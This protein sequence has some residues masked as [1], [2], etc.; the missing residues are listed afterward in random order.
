MVSFNTIGKLLFIGI[1]LI[2]ICHANALFC[3]TNFQDVTITE[4]VQVKHNHNEL[5]PSFGTG[6]AWFDCDNDGDLDLI[7]TNRGRNQLFR[8]NR[9]GLGTP[10]FTDITSDIVADENRD[11]CGVAAADYDNDGDMDLYLANYEED[12]LLQNDGNGNFTDVTE[13]AFPGISPFIPQFGSTAA[14]GDLNNDGWLDIYISN[15]SHVDS[16]INSSD[17]LFIS[18]G[19]SPLTFTDRS[20]LISG[21]VDG[22]GIDDLEGFGLS[23]IIT[24]YNNDGLMDIFATND[25]PLGPEG[26]KLWRNDGN[27]NFTEVISEVGPFTRGIT[28]PECSDVM[29]ITRGDPNH[30]G[31]L[32]YHLTNVHIYGENT[33]LLQNNGEN[34]LNV[35][36]PSGMDKVNFAPE[37]GLL[38]TWGTV[39]IDYDLDTWQDIAFSGGS[40]R[41]VYQPNFLF[42]NETENIAGIP[43]FKQVPRDQSGIVNGASTRTMI[44]A[45]YD[46]DGDPDIFTINFDSTSS[47]F[48][49]ENSNNNNWLIV[50]LKGAGASL[51]NLNGIGAKVRITT[52]DNTS[53]IY[54]T[55]SGSSLG[56][57]DDIGAYFGLGSHE[58]YNLEIKW[59]SGIIQNMENLGV[60]QRIKIEEPEVK[61]NPIESGSYLEKGLSY[62]I[63]WKS[64]FSE[65]VRIL[66]KKDGIEDFTIVESTANNGSFEWI[67]PSEIEV[68]NDYSIR[69]E[70]TTNPLEFG[71]SNQQFSIVENTSSFSELLFPSGGE[72]LEQSETIEILWK[73]NSNENQLSIHL[74]EGNTLVEEIA[75]NIENNGSFSWVIPPT[76]EGNTYHIELVTDEG[77]ISKNESPFSIVKEFLEFREPDL[78]A[79]NMDLSVARIWNEMLLEAIRSDFARPT[80]HARNLFHTSIAM[81]DAWAALGQVGET[82]LLGKTVGDFNCPFDG[83]EKPLNVKRA[84]EEA[85]SYAVYRLLK[86]RFKD[87]PSAPDV[88]ENMDILLNYLGYD[89]TNTSTDYS[90]GSPAALGNYIAEQIIEFGLQDGSNEQNGYANLF[91][92]PINSPLN[93]LESGQSQNINPNRWQPLAFDSFIDQ[94]G[95]PIGGVTPDFLS[96]EWGN[97]VPFSLRKRDLNIYERDDNE[98]RVYHDPGSPAYLNPDG[99]GDSEYYKWGMELVSIWSSPLDPHDGVMWDISPGSQGNIESL[100]ETFREYDEF[101]NLNDGGDPG[102]GYD[103]NPATGEPYEP[104]LVP[105]GDYTRVLAEFW[106]DGPDSETPPGHWFTILNYVNDHPEL[107]K[108]FKGAGRT[109]TNLEWDVKSYFILGGAMHD[110]AI[111]AWGIKGYYDYIRPISAIRYM[112]VLGQSTDPD[113]PNYHPE[114]IELNE[115]YIETVSSDDPLA[116]EVGENVGKIKV[117]A[118]KGHDYITDPTVDEA[119]VDWV[120]AESWVPYQRPTFVTPPFAGYI[121]GHSTFSRAAAEVLTLLTGDEYFPGGMSEF[122]APKNDFLVFEKG[123]STDVVLQWAKYIDASDQCSLSRIWGGIHPPVDDIPGR[124]IGKVIGV[125]AFDHANR[126][127]TGEL[128]STNQVPDNDILIFPNPVKESILNLSVNHAVDQINISVMDLHGKAIISNKVLLRRNGLFQFET[129][130][131][132]KGIYIL[133]I[134]NDQ[135]DLIRRFIKNQ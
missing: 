116:G 23:A 11:G 58:S 25:C 128:L 107:E 111:S 33:T 63:L 124:K 80:V 69:I 16:P 76:L 90:D 67:V 79:I 96:P 135:F 24:D 57:G 70:N 134:K 91:Y 108:K 15:Y 21:D 97:V 32:D 100:P 85:I 115:G 56:G 9:I 46:M 48:R 75:T 4:G 45:D 84:Q 43:Q 113:L 27:L 6:A 5:L 127:F 105:R 34:L 44:M 77:L 22:D 1:P 26:N 98:Y 103:I 130:N 71:S 129:S 8:N 68:G 118:W 36:G 62:D 133:L 42:H 106:A 39:F 82:Y 64:T 112:C 109:L 13:T 2:A 52:P 40:L 73:S 125:E 47:L 29:G 123:P 3:Q 121:S 110:V 18:N 14:W 95:N 101:Y 54:E 55:Y 7:I 12:I 66:L 51:S 92:E 72:L 117:K 59:P 30:D 49:N 35:S 126:Y 93:P 31:W 37:S 131:L 50:D 88:L 74:F 99:D 122:V 17:F 10:G 120:L 28:T 78:G 81:Y 89:E 53:Q 19:D 20:D 65:N 60:N 61:L 102:L 114:G 104:Q 87:S 94:S 86:H 41:D 83:V 119:G 38:F 132:N